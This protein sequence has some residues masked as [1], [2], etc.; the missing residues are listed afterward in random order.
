MLRESN[1]D[2][3]HWSVIY[4][5]SRLE[6]SLFHQHGELCTFPSFPVSL[7]N[8]SRCARLRGCLLT[9][10]WSWPDAGVH[11]TKIES[12]IPPPQRKTERRY[13]S[14][15]LPLPQSPKYSLLHLDIHTETRGSLSSRSF[16]LN[17]LRTCGW[18]LRE[19]ERKK[20]SVNHSIVSNCCLICLVHTEP[21]SCQ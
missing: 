16:L 7:E 2:P 14:C 5:K 3:V 20:S 1:R 10:S 12:H 9:L 6:M 17:C 19:K 11:H 21:S 15:S 8:N 18:N 4:C 13:E